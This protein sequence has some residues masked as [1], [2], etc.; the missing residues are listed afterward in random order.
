MAKAASR[1]PARWLPRLAL[2]A[3]VVTSAV[4]AFAQPVGSP[5]WTY[6]DA[7]ASYAGSSLN[8]LLGRRVPFVDHPGL[9]LT[10][11]GA[12]GFGVDALLR[13]HVP[14]GDSRLDYVRTTMLNLDHA[15]PV[16]RGLAIAFYLLGAALSFLLVSRLLGH[17]TW[18]LAAGLLWIA[19]PG[20][21][22]MSIQFRPDVLLAVLCLCFAYLIGRAVDERSASHYA[23]AGVVTGIAVMVKLHAGGLVVPLALA[24][25]WRPP[26]PGW[27]GEL[28][29]GAA[30]RVR[31]RPLVW[32]VLGAVL[33]A[34]ALTVNGERVPFSP[35]QVQLQVLAA[36]LLP[37]AG[38][39]LL[40]RLLAGRLPRLGAALAVLGL[41][42]ASVVAGLLLPVAL[43]VQDG[44]AALVNIAKSGSGGGVQQEVESFSRPFWDIVDIV[45]TP[46]LLVFAL[47]AVAGVLGV[48][49]KDPRPVVW[50]TGALMLFVLAFARPPAIHYFAPAFALSIP[51]AL[52]A[53]Q[54]TRG[55][56]ASLL[57]WPVV[58]F[59]AWPSFRDRSAPKMETEQFA[60]LVAPSRAIAEAR[61]KPGEFALVPGFWP[62][63]DS[64]WFELVRAFVDYA[65]ERP[66]RY[67]PISGAAAGYA[68]ERE[69]TPRYYIGPQAEEVAGEGRVSFGELG[70]YG[71]R[72]V[73][74]VNLLLELVSGRGVDRLWER[75]DAVYDPWTG[76]FKDPSG[77]YWTRERNVVSNPPRRRYLTDRRLWVDAFGD[78]WDSRGTHVGNDPSLRTSG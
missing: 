15:R 65:P 52:W 19:A 41:I 61:L 37:V 25:A 58:L 10:E 21:A 49:R 75:P 40:A 4:V 31:R 7:D 55:A 11:V 34:L 76:Y 39:L 14:A 71:V 5:W 45:S 47:A 66:Y 32:A 60:A 1:V 12:L 18:G 38:L 74:T 22:P 64:R 24:A 57:V 28:R 68:S 63:P 70:D 8:L 56:A 27:W 35:T 3:A 26:P 53:L 48:V 51:A 72:R 59:I 44:L 6:A 54:R 77:Q 43:E 30:A 16:F 13:G 50:S 62:F 9:P 42:S 36:L 46:V 17:W 29:A 23:A 67:L 78:L 73:Q 20:L 69:L 2:A 33:L